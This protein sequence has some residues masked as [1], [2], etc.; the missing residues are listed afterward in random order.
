MLV[1]WRLSRSAVNRGT[2]SP[3]GVRM[4]RTIVPSEGPKTVFLR[5]SGLAGRLLHDA[6]EEELMGMRRSTIKNK[7]S[8]RAASANAVERTTVARKAARKRAG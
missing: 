2:V 7:K 8:K 5:D 6:T 3:A 1:S 4:P